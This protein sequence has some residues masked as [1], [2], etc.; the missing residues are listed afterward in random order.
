MDDALDLFRRIRRN[1]NS[2]SSSSSEEDLFTDSNNLAM[3][4]VIPV[5]VIVYGGCACI[6]CCYKCRRYLKENKPFRDFA[7]KIRGRETNNESEIT[8]D[9]TENDQPDQIS[10]SEL[11]ESSNQT[12][13]PVE[14]RKPNLHSNNSS[15][16]PEGPIRYVDYDTDLRS[17]MS[18][19]GVQYTRNGSVKSKRLQLGT[20]IALVHNEDDSEMRSDSGI[21]EDASLMQ[22]DSRSFKQR[23]PAEN[24]LLI[25]E[26]ENPVVQYT[27]SDLYSGTAPEASS[28][29]PARYIS[30]SEI[31][32]QTEDTGPIRSMSSAARKAVKNNA[33][34]PKYMN[35]RRNSKERNAHTRVP[36]GE[37]SKSDT[38][39]SFSSDSGISVVSGN[40]LP[41]PVSRNETMSG[42][43]S[44][45][46]RTSMSLT[47][48]RNALN[49][50]GSNR[51]GNK[52]VK[53]KQTTLPKIELKN[54]IVGPWK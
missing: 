18:T 45:G 8:D 47:S 27:G 13:S 6:Y 54:F 19:P 5:M 48:N 51:F 32:I 1:A 34:V 53:K 21:M 33:V 17:A 37:F 44:L 41:E 12:D 11:N 35:W 52:P 36:T 31:A 25:E 7:D 20:P 24:P 23:M 46:R 38:K 14:R 29:M 42:L 9:V 26:I 43:N 49:T 3:F 28:P 15:P 40:K 16:G 2:S 22:L 4:V 39:H 30:T 10:R 50:R